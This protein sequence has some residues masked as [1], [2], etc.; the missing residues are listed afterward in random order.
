MTVQSTI[1]AF[2]AAFVARLKADSA[3]GAAAPP[4]L[5][6]Y[7]LPGVADGR[8]LPREWVFVGDTEP[9]DPTHGDSPYGGGQST[10]AM[11]QLRREERY[12][13]EVVVSVVGSGVDGQRPC[14]ERAFAIAG[15]I[16]TSL[17]TWQA[18]PNAIDL[19]VRWALVTSLFHSE[20]VTENGDHAA[21]VTIDIACA[22]RI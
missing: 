10:G 21:S 13:L 14:T 8:T 4:V 19:V 5:V 12:V 16:E 20:G 9:T 2:K 17:R 15:A 7:G 1:P 18:Q 6:T 11:G 3:I 22:A